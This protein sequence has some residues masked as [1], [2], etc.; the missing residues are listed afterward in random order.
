MKK[1]WWLLL[2]V[3]ILIILVLFYNKMSENYKEK[4]PGKTIWLQGN[5]VRESWELHNPD[6]NI[7]IVT[8]DDTNIS[9]LATHGGVWVDSDIPCTRPLEDWLYDV[10]QPCGFWMYRDGPRICFI[11]SIQESILLQKLTKKRGTS[12]DELCKTDQDFMD[13]WEKVPHKDK[14]YFK[15]ISE[16][17]PVEPVVSRDFGDNVMVVSDCK[18]VDS[19]IELDNLCNSYGIKM[20]VYDKCNFCKHVPSH[21]YSRPLSNKGRE[22]ATFMF[23]I[24]KYYDILPNKIIFTAGNAKKHNRTGKLK[25]MITDENYICDT[26]P[27]Y[28]QENFTYDVHEGKTLVKSEIRPFKK[29]YEHSIGVWDGNKEG[30]CWNGLIKT[31]REKILKNPKH[32]Y[33]NLLN[34]LNIAE[35]TETGHYM[36][37]SLKALLDI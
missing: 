30:P 19:I 6:W 10:L 21:I 27:L 9:V 18:H 22:T 37:R 14:P 26:S 36:E 34:Q 7:E 28:T 8:N 24:I 4:V 29:W 15:E 31:T 16:R 35:S 25:K 13:E 1:V 2:V 32:I 5:N 20:L 33:I 23:F 11:A 17:I 3:L 12:F